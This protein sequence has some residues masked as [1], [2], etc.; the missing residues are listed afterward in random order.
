MD[1]KKL[2]AYRGGGHLT[3]PLTLDGG[4]SAEGV[5]SSGDTWIRYKSGLQMCWGRVRLNGSISSE[6]KKVTFPKPFASNAK[7]FSGSNANNGSSIVM[8][9]WE[10]TT[11]FTIGSPDPQQSFGYSNWLAIGLWK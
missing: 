6:N 2:S 1:I 8:V 9:G 7:V 4:E 3:G 11:T 10:S 5:E